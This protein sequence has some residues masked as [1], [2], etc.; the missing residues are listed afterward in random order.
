MPDMVS[1]PG[2][3]ASLNKSTTGTNKQTDSQT[4]RQLSEKSMVSLFRGKNG[5]LFGRIE[6]GGLWEG[7]WQ[8]ICGYNLQFRT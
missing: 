5:W 8:Q 7:V 3:V 2:T 1:Y 4:K 6:G